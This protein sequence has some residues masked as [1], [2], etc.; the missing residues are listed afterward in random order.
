[1]VISVFV[2]ARWVLMYAAR[3]VDF[4]FS[5]MSLDEKLPPAHPPASKLSNR[6]DKRRNFVSEKKLVCDLFDFLRL[7]LLV[8]AR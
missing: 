2:T 1:M 4:V 5:Q 3:T 7:I 6:E 8:H